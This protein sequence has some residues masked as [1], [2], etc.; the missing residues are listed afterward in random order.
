MMYQKNLVNKQMELI[1]EQAEKSECTFKPKIE[2]NS[3][4]ILQ[5]K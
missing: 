3:E 4:N 5:E 2:K 1:Q